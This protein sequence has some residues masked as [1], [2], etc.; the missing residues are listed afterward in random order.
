MNKNYVSNNIDQF[1]EENSIELVLEHI[2]NKSDQ[3]SPN[4]NINKDKACTYFY[5]PSK[6]LISV[7]NE[8]KNNLEILEP[9]SE[10]YK[11]R[12]ELLEKV[13]Y[14]SFQCLSHAN[15]FKS[16]QSSGG[17]QYD[18]VVYSDKKGWKNVLN[19]LFVN[20]PDRN[21]TILIECK[22]KSS[23]VN[24]EIFSR[25]CCIMD[26]NI[27]NAGIGIF[28]SLS[29]A[30][31]FPNAFGSRQNKLGQCKL[32]QIIYFARTQKYIIVF[33]QQDI[34]SLDQPGSLYK[35][36]REKIREIFLQEGITTTERLENF[37]ELDNL[38][39]HLR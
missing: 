10:E 35:L 28:F 16:F 30:T 11:I 26:H 19:S 17:P 9:N 20:N 31:G 2:L 14:K 15:R 3:G 36:I 27:M 8:F 32:R 38:P 18:L 12:G 6:S 25:L 21:D 33:D 1:L 22:A 5:C 34:F 24:D 4:A 39:D 37:S 13:A 23:K 7:L 29:G